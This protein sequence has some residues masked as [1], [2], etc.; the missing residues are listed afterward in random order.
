MDLTRVKVIV[1]LYFSY[2]KKS[3]TIPQMMRRHSHVN[4]SKSSF[5]PPIIFLTIM[6]Y[7]IVKRCFQNG[8]GWKQSKGIK[9]VPDLVCNIQEETAQ[10]WLLEHF[11]H[12]PSQGKG[13]IKCIIMFRLWWK[14]KKI[15][16][17]R[18][19]IWFVTSYES[20]YLVG[21]SHKL[22]LCHN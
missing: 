1:I 16:D 5:C 10:G 11:W 18:R 4:N 8:A 2:Q 7:Y 12:S 22:S 21:V 17:R 15:L 6:Y 14:K 20:E 13:S 19:I 9:T 3:S